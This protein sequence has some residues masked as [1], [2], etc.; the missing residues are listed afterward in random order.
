MRASAQAGSRAAAQPGISDV[1][2]GAAMS[3]LRRG[4]DNIARAV[5]PSGRIRGVIEF[6][7]FQVQQSAQTPLCQKQFF[8]RNEKK[9]GPSTFQIVS[10][11]IRVTLQKASIRNTRTFS[12][13][14]SG[15]VWPVRAPCGPFPMAA[16]H[17]GAN[18]FLFQTGR[19]RKGWDRG[20]LRC[21]AWES[22][23]GACNKGNLTGSL[24]Q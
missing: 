4:M 1:R 9:E 22:R 23:C 18:S 8:T 20:K 21:P 2:A 13:T 16:V 7:Y 24:S 6:V 11:I 5:R 17:S 19:R 14:S 15:P 12:P 10:R 3:Q